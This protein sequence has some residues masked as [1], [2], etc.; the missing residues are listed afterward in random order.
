MFTRFVY[1]AIYLCAA[2]LQ[3]G[4]AAYSVVSATTGIVTGKTLTDRGV[5]IAAQGDCNIKHVVKDK[6]YCE[7]PVRYNQAGF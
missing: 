7:M 5:S 1:G 6:Y 2:F 4:C 3:S